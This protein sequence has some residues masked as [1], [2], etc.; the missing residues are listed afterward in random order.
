MI[1]GGCFIDRDIYFV[2]VIMGSIGWLLWGKESFV[3]RLVWG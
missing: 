3:W 1:R 2:S